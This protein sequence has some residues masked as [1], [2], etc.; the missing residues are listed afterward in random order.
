MR[1]KYTLRR[2][3]LFLFVIIFVLIGTVGCQRSTSEEQVSPNP[4]SVTIGLGEGDTEF[5]LSGNSAGHI[6]GQSSEFELLFRN[7]STEISWKGE[8]YI[9]LLDNEDILLEITQSAFEIAPTALIQ[10][11][12]T[13]DFPEQLDGPYGL[14]V[15]IP[16]RGASISTIWI[17]EKTTGKVGP[18]PDIRAYR[19][20]SQDD[21]E[22]ARDFVK[23]SPTYVF[24]GIDET[25]QLTNTAAY[26][27][28]TVSEGTTGDTIHGCV[29]TFTF[30]SSS[31]GYGDRSGQMVAQVITPHEAVITV[32]Q[33]KI[34]SAVLDNEWDMVNQKLLQ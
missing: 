33:G 14:T 2:S 21:L 18:W 12:I 29:F 34:I 15:I 24:D 26:S 11:F 6:A 16:G 4:F 25:L 19:S 17:G 22:L 31:A 8:Y 28:Q 30:D 10:K 5:T 9:V 13:V 23:N 27:E 1:T 3:L 7:K 20:Y 32:E